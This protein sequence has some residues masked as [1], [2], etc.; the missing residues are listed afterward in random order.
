MKCAECG[1]SATNVNLQGVPVCAAHVKTKVKVPM[2]PNCGLGM[3]ARQGKFGAFWGC[4][5]F[6]SCDGIRKM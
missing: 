5:A 6:P 4:M 1:K 2:C 3:V